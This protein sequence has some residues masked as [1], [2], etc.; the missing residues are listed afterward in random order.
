MFVLLGFVT[1]VWM[2]VKF[3]DLPL[4]ASRLQSYTVLVIFPDA[5][6]I[7]KDTP[8]YFCGYPVGR[9]MFVSPPELDKEFPEQHRHIVRV[10]LAIN[11]KYKDIPDHV[12]IIIV[13]RGLGSSF[14]EFQV[15]PD[16]PANG[17]LHDESVVRGA[18]STA[19]EFFPPAVQKKLEDLVD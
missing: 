10:S 17:Y 4:F 5:P 15:E 19:S 3:G 1:F 8:V 11:K 14:I 18:V 2:L 9:V 12:Q 13:K 7:Q 6:G 16:K